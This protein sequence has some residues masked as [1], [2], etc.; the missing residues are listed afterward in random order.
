MQLHLIGDGLVG[1]MAWDMM[2]GVDLL[3][4]RPGIDKERIILLGGVAGG[5]DPAAVTGALDPRIKAV[6]PFNF[7]GPQP[8]SK[9]PLPDDADKTFNFAGSGTGLSRDRKLF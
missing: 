3:L 4:A 7:G 6:G 2:R 9:Y 8:E 1:W 5:G